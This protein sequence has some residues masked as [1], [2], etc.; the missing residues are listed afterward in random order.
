M[1]IAKNDTKNVRPKTSLS[2]K[3]VSASRR[4]GLKLSV[5][6][7]GKGKLSATAKSGAKTVGK[8]SKTVKKA[9]T[10]ALKLKVSR[11]GELS[12]R[13]TWKPTGGTAVSK[14]VTAKVK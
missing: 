1:R 2:V 10:A 12:V 7:S 3:V 13:V 8:A 9:G 14:T 4:A 5:K 6:V 11:K